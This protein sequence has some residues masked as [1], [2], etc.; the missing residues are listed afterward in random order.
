MGFGG[1][2]HGG[3]SFGGQRG[4]SQMTVTPKKGRG[5][6]HVES[7][8]LMALSGLHATYLPPFVGERN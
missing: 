8:S 3:W 4:A 6:T 7:V 1:H 5:E 2:G